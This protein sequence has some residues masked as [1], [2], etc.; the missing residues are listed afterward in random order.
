MKKILTLLTIFVCV[1]MYSQTHEF[2]AGMGYAYYIGDL[3]IT[4]KEN[5]LLLASVLDHTDLKNFKTNL[6]LG[7]RMNFRNQ[8]SLGLTYNMMQISGYDS[9]N[10]ALGYDDPAFG[11]KIR[12]LSFF[13]TVNMASLDIRY[14]PLRRMAKWTNKKILFS[15]YVSVGVGVFGFN[16]KTKYNGQKVE[17]QPLGTEGQGIEGQKPKYSLTE[18]T[19]PVGFGIKCYTPNR[20]FSAGIDLRYNLT[21]TDYLDDV[22]GLHADEQL[23]R[24]SYDASR[25][26]TIIDLANRI[27]PQYSAYPSGDPR[28]D[29]SDNDH[30]VSGLFQIS[31]Y[32]PV[33]KKSPCCN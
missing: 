29:A 21:F 32:I 22:S 27:D 17:L 28:G 16:P 11:R 25:A 30:I 5:S 7:Y 18:W 19:V 12:N 8:W 23:I 1:E 26:Q 2:N 24:N 6:S 31:Y 4:N 13:S 15:P 20:K 33:P 14:E 3:N 10:D 9:D